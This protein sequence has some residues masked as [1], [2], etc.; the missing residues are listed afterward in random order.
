MGIVQKFETSSFKI[1]PLYELHEKAGAKFGA[2]AGWQMPLTYPL[3]VMKEHLHTRAHAGL[4]DISHMKLIAVEGPQATEF[5]SY[6]LPVDAALLKIGQSRYNYLLNEQAGI[7]DDLIIT[8]LAECRFILVANAS[9]AQA[10]VAELQKRSVGFECQII[11]LER[12][13]LALQ[14]PQAADVIADAGLPGNELLFMQGF[15]PQQD[16]FMTRSGY[17]GED[18][19]EIALPIEQAHT[20]ALKLLSDPRVEW[21][22]LAARDSLRL[23]AGLC[24]HGNDITSDTTPIEAALTWAVPKNV[25]EKARFYG[26]KAFLEAVQKGPSRCRVGLKP[27]T[28]Q[29]IRSGAVLLDDK[30]NQIGRVTSGGF[31]PSFD[32][33]VAMGYVPVDWKA[34]G[35]EVFTE[36]RGKR[37]ALSVH[38]L[39]FV[40]QRYFKG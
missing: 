31:G 36:L 7:L 17:T 12:V 1:L 24:L 38:S 19:F 14:G 39:P 4:F 15:E 28:R 5:L 37:I 6:A 29:P 40:E 3:G 23:E 11:A 26:A 27:Q 22:G 34:E 20:L 10:D 25:R 35:T 18:G 8:R 2:F 16:W 9:N 33:P 32:G 21:V 30:G 13:L